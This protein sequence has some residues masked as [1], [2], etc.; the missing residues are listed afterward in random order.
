MTLY[1]QLYILK[2]TDGPGPKPGTDP[3][4]EID[5]PIP[6]DVTVPNITL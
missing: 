3:A 6:P 4:P 1:D 5:P 2:F